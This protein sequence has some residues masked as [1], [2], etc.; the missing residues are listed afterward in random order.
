MAAFALFGLCEH[1]LAA[2]ARIRRREMA[3][4]AM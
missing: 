1:R 4:D 3:A 2:A